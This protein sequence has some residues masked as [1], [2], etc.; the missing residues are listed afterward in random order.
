MCRGIGPKFVS[1]Q[2]SIQTANRDILGVVVVGAAVV[3]GEAV[4]VGDA[5]ADVVLDA[6]V[7]VASPPSESLCVS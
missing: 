3:V 1:A 5:V 7:V 6:E 4:V 2:A